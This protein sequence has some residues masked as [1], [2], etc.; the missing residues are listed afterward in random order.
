[1]HL[2]PPFPCCRASLVSRPREPLAP[3][4]PQSWSERELVSPPSRL[5]VRRRAGRGGPRRRGWARG[6]RRGKGRQGR[7]RGGLVVVW[8]Q[9]WWGWCGKRW[10]RGRREAGA[11]DRRLN[12]RRA[13][14][15]WWWRLGGWWSSPEPL[16]YQRGRRRLLS[17]QR[18]QRRARSQAAAG[19]LQGEPRLRPRGRAA[20]VSP[21]R[22]PAS[23]GL[24]PGVRSAETLNSGRFGA[25]LGIAAMEQ[26]WCVPRW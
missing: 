12:P 19:L 26:D 18:R 6:R 7:R 21:H 22:L 9:G 1:M 3:P 20:A 24:G 17:P 8:K 13:D 11:P 14:P 2:P 23:R 25:T 10:R 15:P 5:L 16:Q 4:T